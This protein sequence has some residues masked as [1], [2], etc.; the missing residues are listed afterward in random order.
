MI[1]P[2]LSA[3]LLVLSLALSLAMDSLAAQTADEAAAL[4]AQ[5]DLYH[6]GEGVPRNFASAAGFYEQAA[7]AGNAHAQNQLGRYYYEGLGVA[8]DRAQALRWLRAA[9][10]QGAPQ[11]LFD[12][13]VALEESGTPDDLAAAAKAYASAAELGLAEAAVSLGLLYQDGRGVEQDYGRARDLYTGPAQ[14]GHARAQNNL[15][16]LYVR[17]NGVAQ[18]YELASQL[19]AAAAEQGLTQAMTNL[20][21]MYENGFGVEQD[22][23]RAAQLYRMAGQQGAA[24]QPGGLIYD[25]RLKP[26]APEPAAIEAQASAGDPLAQFQLAWILATDPSADHAAVARA[27]QLFRA[28]A[29]SGYPPAMANLG[30]MYFEGRGVYQDYVLSLKW[31]TLASAAGLPDGAALSAR[32]MPYLT[33]GQV[34]EAQSMAENFNP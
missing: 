6:A 10:D 25:T 17:G 7:K 34:N 13:A 3:S 27:A 8:Q 33:P 32:V 1:L 22:D 30:L 26:V 28:A 24:N 12:L 16:L 19:F 18:D 9:A 20:G 29:Q 2:R 31:I 4:A 23:A 14:A 21:V 11:H 15:G 5:G